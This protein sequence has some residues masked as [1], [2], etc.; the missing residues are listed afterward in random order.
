VP[1]IYLVGFKVLF[2]NIFN[3][4]IFFRQHRLKIHVAGT[5]IILCEIIT[6][7]RKQNLL[8]VFM[9]NLFSELSAKWPCAFVARTEAGKFTGGLI[10]EKYLANLDSAG[11]GPEG[12]IRCG[13][14]IVYPV[15]EFVKWLEKRSAVVPGRKQK[16]EAAQ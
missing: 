15:A 1:S 16:S 7:K 6:P 9:E 3:Y 5:S 12:R 11:K 8:G 2:C 10:S 4:L 13:R 14:K